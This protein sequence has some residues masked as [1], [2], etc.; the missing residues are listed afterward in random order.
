MS[1][2][3]TYVEGAVGALISE[4]TG[5]PMNCQQWGTYEPP[6]TS[7]TAGYCNGGT[8]DGELWQQCPSKDE[9][10]N[11]RN[12]R[13]MAPGLSQLRHPQS[14]VRVV[15]GQGTMPT[16][17]GPPTNIPQGNGIR[18]PQVAQIVTPTDTSNPYLG[19]P[20]VLNSG[21]AGMHSPTFLPR[22]GEHWLMRFFKNAIQGAANAFGHHIAEFTQSVDLFPFETPPPP[23]KEKPPE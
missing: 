13:M 3:E 20:K 18:P 1:N 15:G 2:N 16:R 23:P 4:V 12:R 6:G 10:R 22:P 5:K 9:C 19:T 7:P 11:E 17:F 8:V 21:R 14:V